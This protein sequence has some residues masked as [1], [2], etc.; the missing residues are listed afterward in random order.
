MWSSKLV[1]GVMV[2]LLAGF[3]CR[4]KANPAFDVALEFARVEQAHARLEAAAAELARC[5]Q[6]ERAS[7]RRRDARG[8][9][10]LH[11]AQKAFD[12]SWIDAQRAAAEFL[13]RAL[14]TAPHAPETTRALERVAHDAFEVAAL[15]RTSTGDS[16]AA[17]Q[18]LRSAQQT[19][20]WAGRPIPG[21][22]AHA[23][24]AGVQALPTPSLVRAPG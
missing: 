10:A 17:L 22:L 9:G 24:A 5:T 21:E 11:G 2:M 19:F 14:R 1:A 18:I 8:A 20:A 3:G 23:L 6:D 15:V 12:S 13:S 4:Y 7:G 16:R